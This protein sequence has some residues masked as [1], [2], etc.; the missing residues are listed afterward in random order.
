MAELTFQNTSVGY[1]G[2]ALIEGISFS[3]N[4]GEIVA[5]I[6]PNGAGKTTILKTAAGLLTPVSGNVLLFEKP[7]SEYSGSERAKLMSVMLTD[8][9]DVDY[10]TCREVVSIGR[11][12]YTGMFGSLKESDKAMVEES[13]E[14]IGAKSIA[15]KEYR[16]LSDG[17]KQRVLLARAIVSEPKVLLLDEPTGFLDI[18]YKIS[19]F[20]TLKKLTEAKQIAVLLSMHETEL[21]KKVADRVICISRENRVEKT[22][23]AADV[24]T[25]DYMEHL[26]SITPGKYEDYY[27]KNA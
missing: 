12:Q 8:R 20:E 1:G 18:G 5:L 23:S 15:D 21:V 3:V 27:G 16:T 9:R 14:L 13:L 24:I 11:Y 6:G 22:G 19:F 17:Q 25:P 10:M 26:F 7:V 2:K 4:K